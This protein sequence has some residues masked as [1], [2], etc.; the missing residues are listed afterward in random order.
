MAGYAWSILQCAMCFSH[1]GWRYTWQ[2]PG[3]STL[4]SFFGLCR[5]ALNFGDFPLDPVV[6]ADEDS[7]PDGVADLTATATA[8]AAA[9]TGDEQV[10]ED[11]WV[12]IRRLLG[13]RERR[14]R[15]QQNEDEDEDEEDE[16]EDEEDEE[17]MDQVEDQDDH[18][19]DNQQQ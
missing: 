4:P 3:S 18:D 10:V 17:A 7:T 1:L 2:G 14:R 15:G 8:A 19:T 12:W 6:E 11:G 5:A 16:E 9:A 13:L